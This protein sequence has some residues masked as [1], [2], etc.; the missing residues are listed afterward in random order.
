MKKRKIRIT[1]VSS[2]YSK[3]GILY[4][5]FADRT[6]MLRTARKV[7]DEEVVNNYVFGVLKQ[8]KEYGI[9]DFEVVE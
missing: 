2:G 4:E 9:I 5:V 8:N 1:S 3:D 6:L 7:G